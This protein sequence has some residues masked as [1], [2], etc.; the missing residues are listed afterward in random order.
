[1]KTVIKLDTSKLL[2]Y[3]D[4]DGIGRAPGSDRRPSRLAGGKVGGEQMKGPSVKVGATGNLN[5]K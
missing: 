3:A 4:S 1:M 5:R 2:G